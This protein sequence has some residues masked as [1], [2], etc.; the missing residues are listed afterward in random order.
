MP[1][2]SP[3]TQPLLVAQA[4]SLPRL[5]TA[6]APHQLPF[7]AALLAQ[8]TLLSLRVTLVEQRQASERRR[9]TTVDAGSSFTA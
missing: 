4:R 8:G 1:A 6:R 5:D 3:L 7:A 2:P 9:T